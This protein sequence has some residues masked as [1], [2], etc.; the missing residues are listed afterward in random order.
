[1]W[2]R[3]CVHLTPGWGPVL[4]DGAG[5]HYNGPLVV[6]FRNTTHHTREYRDKKKQIGEIYSKY[7]SQLIIK[8]TIQRHKDAEVNRVRET[9]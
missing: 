8:C 3:L 9:A 2:E 1:M 6:N 5:P 7:N 4:S